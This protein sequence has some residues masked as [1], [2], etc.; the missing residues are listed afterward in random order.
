M[1]RLQYSNRLEN[2]IA[3][4]AEAVAVHQRRDPLERVSIV[5]PNRVVEQ[6]VR[7]RLAESIGVAANL[8]FPF[9]RSYLAELLQSTDKNFKILEA[10]DLQLVLFECL[11]STEHRD[12]PGLKPARDY[13]LGGSKTDADVELRTLLLAAQLARLFREYS[14]SRR[15][16]IRKWPTARRSD[17]DA[18]SETESW[19][20]HLWQLVFDSHGRVREE[21]LAHRE[22]RLMM[23][24]DAFEATEDLQLKAALPDVLHIFSS[25]YAG[26]AYADIFARLGALGDVRIYALNPCREFWE[27]VDTSRRI[28]IAGWA[29]RQDKL[30]EKINE[31]EDP[32]SLNDSS[33]PPALR[34]W[35]RPGRE[36]I[37]LLNELSQCDFAPLFSDPV[38]GESETASV[39]EALQ[40][41]ILE[42][43]PQPM[44]IQDGKGRLTEAR[45]SFLACPGIRREA[46]I[47]ANEIWSIV[48]SNEK[49]A[50]EGKAERIRFH[51]IAVLIPESAVDD[52]AAHIE[53]V[54]RKQHRI[55]IDLVSRTSAGAS[56]VAEAVELLLQLPSGRFSRA[57][58]IR[59][60]THPALNPESESGIDVEKW[61]RWSE[62]LG[63]F[64]GADDY[65]LKDTYIPPG[66]YH[67]DQAIKRLALGTMMTG[68]RG[69]DST[70]YSAGVSG[71]SYIPGEVAQD[72]LETAARFI[73]MARSLIA[74][75]ISIRDAHLTPREWSLMLGEFVNAYIRPEGAID[76]Q[77]RDRFLE[78]IETIGESELSVGA[79]SYESAREVIAARVA[80]LESRRGQYSGR[81]IAIGSFTSLRSIPFKIIFALGQNDAIFPER[82]HNEPLD[83]RRLK[84]AAGDVSP[85]ERDRYLFLETILAARERIFFSYV[86]RNAKTGDELEPSPVIRELQSILRGFIDEKTLAKLTV[87]HPISRY[88][89]KY[90]PEF[91][92]AGSSACGAEFASFDPD[93]RRGARMLA[94]RKKINESMRDST[95]LEGAGL[96]D[97][98]GEELRERVEEDLQFAKFE[99]TP[100]AT[101][102]APMEEIALPIAAIR[103]YLECPLQGAARYSLGMLED[104]DAPEDAEDEPVEQSRLNRTV[105]LR[106]I[107]WRA[108]G[109]LDVIGKE[110]ARE[111]RIA[112]AHGH[113]SAG[114]FAEAAKASDDSALREWIAQASE[115][116][117][118][119][120]DRWKDSR[121]GR[122]DEFAD[123]A[124]MLPPISLNAEIHRHDGTIMTR[125][126][127]LYGTIRGVSPEA[128]A[129]I[130]CVLR[131]SIKSK[132]FL[133]AFL[134]AI[135]LAA[136]GAK[137]PDKFRA[138]VI[139]ANSEKKADGLRDFKPLEQNSAIAYLTAI[140]GDLL[141]TGNTYFLPIEAI[142]EVVK[143]LRNDKNPRDLVD[144]VEQI[145]L[146]NPP[147]C[148]S[149]YGPVR[150][151]RDF[152]PPDEK[153][154]EQ[155]V[156]RR[157]KPIIGIFK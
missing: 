132:D 48:R 6:F 102:L 87:T 141:S 20:R 47:V 130:N 29:H 18:M 24:P 8:K 92:A 152:D 136:S 62:T 127:R 14:I 40:Q 68:Q 110:Y 148:S 119:D 122:A 100:A 113:A 53:S 66:L 101:N 49:L 65:D 15:R 63:I 36:Y 106:K 108:G 128:G 146:N 64:F 111:V 98:L 78:A 123:V 71:P 124:E 75:A 149:D 1:I 133:P 43:A 5:V 9:L 2:L 26:N 60:L 95:R 7:Y 153:T 104:E 50:A 76:E 96:L 73:R 16:M 46:E 91:G 10:D 38:S 79:M 134:N 11:R 140:V 121:I 154:I 116:G 52:Y 44:N 94:L 88:D 125:R 126:V 39:L 27:D 32:F 35:G 41:N 86:A 131:K 67:W 56:R 51:E 151:P 57:E 120:L 25:S 82:D 54:F 118:S 89:L 157:F 83:L 22:T 138:I 135:V 112:Q 42:R 97:C 90:F 85:A 74:D 129:A 155:I 139:R 137:L 37:R 58:M 30:G 156:A 69:G 45:I 70:F 13:I 144:V 117:V 17:V 31:S 61:R 80:D 12:D 93:A 147:T 33:D 28:A 109:K 105:M 59:L 77:V 143:Q 23:L 115:A 55:P 142:E 103:R 145:L 21:W 4:L 107:F 81:G 19:Q 72:E 34:L 114:R 99:S 150:N 84:R 3:P